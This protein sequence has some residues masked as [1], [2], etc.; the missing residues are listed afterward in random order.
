MK[1][2]SNELILQI[3]GFISSIIFLLYLNY[4]VVGEWFII[5]STTIFAMV[6]FVFG[7]FYLLVKRS[8]K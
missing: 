4:T 3:I 5:N 6:I 2:D 8:N 7:V 1:D